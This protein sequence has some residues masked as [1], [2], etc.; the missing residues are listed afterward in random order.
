MPTPAD[1]RAEAA[2]LESEAAALRTRAK[3]LRK[4]AAALEVAERELAGGGLGV[5]PHTALRPAFPG[6]LHGTPPF[7]KSGLH[8]QAHSAT[9]D[10]MDSSTID[11]ATPKRTRGV[12]LKSKGPAAKVARLLGISLAEVARRVKENPFS[13]RTWDQR[14]QLPPEVKAKLADLVAAHEVDLKK[15]AKRRK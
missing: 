2:R 15:S 9:I 13:M 3:K 1:L 12:P 8:S 10:S 5:E 7:P 11:S 14:D 4:F 6:P